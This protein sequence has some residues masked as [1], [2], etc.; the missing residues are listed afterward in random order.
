M[1]DRRSIVGT[2]A[3]PVAAAL[4]AAFLGA[5]LLLPACRHAVG[6]E[7]I[8]ER[9]QARREARRDRAEARKEIYARF[10]ADYTVEHQGKDRSFYV[11]VPSGYDP[12]KPMPVVMAFH[13]GMG[14]AGAIEAQSRMAAQADR[15]YFLAVYPEGTGAPIAPAIARSWNGGT[16]CD[17]AKKNG[18][19]DVGFIGK[20][21]DFLAK[22]YSIDPKRV[23]A[24]GISN[25]AIMSYRLACDLSDRIAAIA[26]VAGPQATETCSP[27]KPVSIIHFHGTGDPCS[28]FKGGKGG[29]CAAKAMGF[30]AKPLFDTPSIP[31]IVKSWG[32]RNG[33]PKEARQTFKK[34]GVTCTTYGPG[35][36]GSEATLCAIEGTGHTWPGGQ[37]KLNVSLVGTVTQEIDATSM[38]WEFFQRHPRK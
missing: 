20:M 22:K 12:K 5:A 6:Q 7:T 29:G 26:P 14:H 32:E 8:L 21:L 10:T 33:A 3:A 37:E 19:D 16:C 31:D 30:E 25:G 18:A 9:R 35:R 28:P 34:G 38:M 36:E 15:S 23:Y 2:P 17:P 1:T 27:S 4:A 11:H 24:T 13:G